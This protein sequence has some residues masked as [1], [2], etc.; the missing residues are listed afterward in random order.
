MAELT[1]AGVVVG[2]VEDDAV[3]SYG[4]VKVTMEEALTAWKG[5]L[6]RRYLKPYPEQRKND[7]PAPE[8]IEAQQ[9]ADGGTIDENGCYHAGSV[10]VCK[11]KVAKPAYLFRYSQVQTANTTAQRHLNVQVQKW[12]SKYSKT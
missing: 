8:S 3:L 5:T 12:M 4:D 6:E 10:Y 7:G 1:I 11:H 9:A 2:E